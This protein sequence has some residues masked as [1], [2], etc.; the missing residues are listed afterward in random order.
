MWLTPSLYKNLRYARRWW[1]V[2]T[3]ACCAGPLWI[4]AFHLVQPDLLRTLYGSLDEVGAQFGLKGLSLG[5]TLGKV[6]MTAS[7]V[8]LVYG[9][10]LGDWLI[11][12]GWRQLQSI[13]KKEAIQPPPF[14]YFATVAA[15]NMVGL[16][17]AFV[18]I[19]V[20]GKP[21]VE[22]AWQWLSLKGGLQSVLAVLICVLFWFGRD[23]LQTI[24]VRRDQE[25]FGNRRKAF[26]ARLAGCAFLLAFPLMVLP[27]LS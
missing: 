23:R 14:G 26:C 9:L 18:L 27:R 13:L 4:L 1:Q 10:A 17:A 25:I 22:P 12:H 21:F 20:A 11:A 2:L 8:F 19:I 15:G 5:N 6:L 3:C 7:V 24:G 16:G